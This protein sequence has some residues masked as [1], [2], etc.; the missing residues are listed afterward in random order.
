MSHTVRDGVRMF[1]VSHVPYC[2]ELMGLVFDQ[3]GI[4]LQELTSGID[5][6]VDL[7]EDPDSCRR[8]FPTQTTDSDSNEYGDCQ[9]SITVELDTGR[10]R[11]RLSCG[12]SVQQVDACSRLHS[13]A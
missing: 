8:F 5:E 1:S 4:S 6:A 9:S 2:E 12:S 3:E 10:S 13:S 7:C 11:I